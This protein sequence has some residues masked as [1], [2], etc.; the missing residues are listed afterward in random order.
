SDMYATS[1]QFLGGSAVA[2]AVQS[3]AQSNAL[4]IAGSQAGWGAMKGLG[5][6]MTGAPSSVVSRAMT[7]QLPMEAAGRYMGAGLGRIAGGIGSAIG[8][9]AGRLVGVEAGL[10]LGGVGATVGGFAGAAIGGV[11]APFV[12]G[13]AAAD[14]VNS[15]VFS[16]YMHGRQAA[17]VL[18]ES[19]KG[20]YTGL[21]TKY[22]PLGMSARA[23]SDLGF[24]IA[25]DFTRSMAWDG[26]VGSKVLAFGQQAGLYGDIKASNSDAMRKRTRDIAEQVKVVMQIFNEPSMQ[27][28]IDMIGKLATQGGAKGVSDIVRVSQ[29]FK[30]AS[31]LTG[32]STQ[33]LMN[34]V[35]Q[36]GQFM[37]G[38]QGM[39]PYLGSLSAL[40]AYSGISSAYKSGLI[41][42]NALAMMGGREG[43][44]QSILQ[45]Q[46]GMARSPY[47]M[48][49][50][51]NQYYGRGTGGGI[52]GNLS[53]FGANLAKDPLKAMGEFYATQ[54]MS[55]S[56]QLAKDPNA[57][58]KQVFQMLDLIPG[59]KDKNGRYN[60]Q[61]VAV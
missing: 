24:D 13:M 35:G 26:D 60:W 33:Q 5:H 3:A 8:N 34:T 30:N 61:S 19:Y 14:A 40:N 22:S 48:I 41:S 36:Q 1:L 47:N 28:A 20:Q 23:S 44:T 12:V 25:K 42:T 2:L 9:T 57:A 51:N 32:T 52:V 6:A 49:M 43:A 15:M 29:A 31:A 58:L 53:T 50:A 46:L 18:R 4:R 11:V 21:G 39:L 38:Q 16:P 17:D 56:D 59:A 37:F 7:T 27:G 54:N 10:A 45:A 55:I